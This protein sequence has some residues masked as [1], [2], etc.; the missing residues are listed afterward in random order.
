M[1]ITQACS[2]TSSLRI[3]KIININHK[4]H[5]CQETGKNANG[6]EG[7]LQ[8]WRSYFSDIW[9]TVPKTG[10]DYR[11]DV[12]DIQNGPLPNL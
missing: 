8:P 7:E 10:C 3:H 5:K 1:S 2:Q 11:R 4:C 6:Y 9:G 12:I